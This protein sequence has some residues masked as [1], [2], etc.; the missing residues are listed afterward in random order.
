MRFAEKILRLDQ[1]PQFQRVDAFISHLFRGKALVDGKGVE[2][3]LRTVGVQEVF[4]RLAAVGL[5][6]QQL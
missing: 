1:F 3:Q 2:V 4:F 5:V 6:V